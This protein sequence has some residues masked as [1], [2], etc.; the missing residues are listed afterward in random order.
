V[1]AALSAALVAAPLFAQ[2]AEPLRTLH[3]TVSNAEDGAPLSGATVVLLHDTLH[4]N[5]LTTAAGAFRLQAPSGAVRLAAAR[6]GF[7]PETLSVAAADTL[8]RLRLRPAPVMLDPLVVASERA[9]SA[10]SSQALRE[11]DIRLRPRES[12]QELLR[13]SPGLVIAQHAGGGKAEQ[14]FLRGFDADHGTDVAVSVDGL[15]VNMVSH[16]HGQG[17][18]DL[19]FLIPELVE[20]IE[21]RKG[22]Y[23]VRDGDFATAGAVAFHTSDRLARPL[24]SVRG[25]SFGTAALVAALP[26]GGGAG[27]GGGYLAAAGLSSDGP[28]DLS[29]RHRRMNLFGKWTAPAG[30]GRE[31]F[32]QGSTFSSRWDASGQIPERAVRDGTITRFGAIDPTEGGRTGKSDMSVGLRSSPGAGAEWEAAAFLTRYTFDLFSNFTFFL[33]DPVRGDGIEQVDERWLAGARASYARPNSLFGMSGRWQGGA[34]ARADRMDVAVHHQER[35]ERLEARVDTRIAEKHLYAWTGQELRLAGRARL[36]LGV[37][38]DLFRFDV[39]DRLAGTPSELPHAS[40]TVW[41]GIASPRASLAVELP[42]QTTLFLNAGGGFHSNDARGVILA[43]ADETVLPRAWGSEIG[44]RA[45]GSR[46]T[47]AASLWHLDLES[48]LV[49]SGDE[50]TTEPSGRTRRFGLDLEGRFRALPWLWADADLNLARGRFRD[51]PEGADRIPLAPT[52]T[53]TAGLTVRDAGPAAG[54]LRMRHIGSRPADEENTIRA[55]GYTVW[56]A[57][58]S[59]RL[60]ALTLSL[61]A[62]N[63]FDTRWNEAQFTTTSR[64]RNEPEA[65][66]E[67]HFTPGAPRGFQV[68]ASYRF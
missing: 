64:L 9:Y 16:G 32:A 20:R 17:Y 18:A 6:I 40:G 29:Q 66:T 30:S 62:D 34:G 14:I 27:E 60:G 52:V 13:L 39:R 11:V 61:T 21:V 37:R 3:G 31:W 24:V 55:L 51:E 26:F 5:A 49:Y 42:A 38:G 67:L 68:G 12:S 8:V 15:P 2:R 44:A 59:Y 50:G 57:F 45:V 48:E 65:V 23:D 41:K 4:R 54:G 1:W 47:L 28:F 33:D 19:H 25:G 10:A 22:P 7:A 53:A 56:E 58:V 43:A 35:R 36:E 63:L 46:G